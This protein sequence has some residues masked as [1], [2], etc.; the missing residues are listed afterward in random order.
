MKKIEERYD[1]SA[2]EFI[3]EYLEKNR[4]VL[5]KGSASYWKNRWTPESLKQGYGDRKV[6]VETKEAFVYERSSKTISLGE[7]VDSVMESQEYR[8]RSGSFLSQVRELQEEFQQNNH[9]RQYFGD[10]G[11]IKH[12]FWI[13]PRGNTPI[14]HHDTFYDNLNV[15]VFGEKKFILI[16]PSDYRR[17]RAHF[18]AESPIDPVSPDLK[19][20]P[21]FAKAD[22]SE[23]RLEPGDVLFI[24]QFWWHYVLALEVSVN[25]S[26]WLK[27]PT[28]SVHTVT[29]TMPLLPRLVYRTLRNE[30][31]EAFIDKNVRLYYRVYNK[32]LG[33]NAKPK[34]A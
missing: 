28:D 16:P 29:A 2:E 31:F 20:Y 13:S 27:S 11:N 24:P 15:Q 7:L 32:I 18:F 9:F 25:I 6:V 21:D 26:T 4:P 19:R 3:H 10:S 8:L 14:L 17:M 33:N 30:G 22:V 1:V 12:A 5:L 23:A 34:N